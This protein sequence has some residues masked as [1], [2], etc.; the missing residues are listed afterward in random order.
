[1]ILTHGW[2]GSI[3]EFLDSIGPLVNPIQYGGRAEDAFHVVV[4]SLPEFGFSDRPRER[5]WDHA[6]IARAWFQLMDRL[7]YGDRWVAQ[8]GDWGSVVV[9]VLAKMRPPGLPAVHTNWPLVVP[10]QKP[11]HMT[12]QEQRAWT[13]T[14]DFQT[15]NNG[16]WRQQATRPQTLGYALQD[17]PVGLAGWIFEKFQAWTDNQGRPQD[18]LS[19]DRM[20]D[21]IS[22]YWFTGTIAS[23]MRL[24]L[25]GAPDGPGP[26]NAGKIDLPITASIFPQE[27]FTA[28]RSWANQL[29]SDIVYWN[30]VDHGGHFAAMEQPGIFVNELREAFRTFRP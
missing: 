22:L 23:S 21:N 5:G 11:D 18:A 14:V 1:L 16:Y 27:I 19:D 17:S 8:G 24:Y 10:L 7:G 15:V 29:W 28:P 20:L 3:V 4:P 9:H 12:P 26:F 25:Q 2:P 6:R 30:E 13:Q